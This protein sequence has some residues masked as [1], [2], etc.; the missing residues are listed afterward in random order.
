MYPTFQT[1]TAFQR[2]LLSHA[3][4]IG[5]TCTSLHVHTCTYMYSTFERTLAAT[6]RNT[7]DRKNTNCIKLRVV[8]STIRSML[9]VYQNATQITGIKD[10]K[11]TCQ[12]AGDT[13]NREYPVRLQLQDHK[14]KLALASIIELSGSKDHEITTQRHKETVCDIKKSM[15]VF[16]LYISDG[17]FLRR[18]S[19]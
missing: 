12:G 3:A 1:S 5:S 4:Q 19:R 17:H 11:M 15:R 6:S 2:T 10:T 18:R 9:L 8:T 16:F 14:A 7:H 13:K